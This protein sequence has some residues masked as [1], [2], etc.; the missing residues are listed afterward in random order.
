MTPDIDS[1]EQNPDYGTAESLN[2]NQ[3]VII[4]APVS[5]ADR[6]LNRH[7]FSCCSSAGDQ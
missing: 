2:G 5:A 1:H 7:R 4:S 6:C 3:M